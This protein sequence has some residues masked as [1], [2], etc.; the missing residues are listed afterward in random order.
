[1]AS[2]R[3]KVTPST[4][5]AS[6]LSR[7][8]YQDDS[9]TLPPL[10]LERE[11]LASYVRQNLT[12]EERLLLMLRYAEE[13]HFD[14]IAGIMAMPQDDVEILHTSI[15]DRLEQVLAEAQSECLVGAG[16]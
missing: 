8:A 10:P 6:T 15:V 2:S 14:E 7:R 3:P 12:R 4:T 13:L 16:V 5:R 9:S 11:E 1:M